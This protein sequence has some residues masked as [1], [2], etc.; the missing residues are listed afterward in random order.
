MFV[1]GPVCRRREKPVQL[2]GSREALWKSRLCSLAL[3]HMLSYVETRSKGISEDETVG[4]K[5]VT[6]ISQRQY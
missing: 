1:D 3:G 6:G 2:R 5:E 4:V